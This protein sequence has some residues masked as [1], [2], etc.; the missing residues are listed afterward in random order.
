MMRVKAFLAAAAVV[1]VGISAAASAENSNPHGTWISA[2]GGAKVR[3]AS[4]GNGIC[5]NIVWLRERLDSA[6]GRPK[7]DKH[8]P[9]EAKRSRPMLGLQVISGMKPDGE[10]RYAGQVYNADDGKTYRSKLTLLSAD[11]AK[12]EGCVLVFCKGETWTRV[13]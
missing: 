12:V 4:C 8:N 5:G 2:D 11:K 9:S 6:T 3:I 7:T 10:N 1:A 13:D